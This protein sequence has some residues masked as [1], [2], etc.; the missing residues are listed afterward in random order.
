MHHNVSHARANITLCDKVNHIFLAKPLEECL[1]D[2]D[3]SLTGICKKWLWFLCI[4][5]SS[6]SFVDYLKRK[7]D[8]VDQRLFDLDYGSKH[9]DKDS[10][11]LKTTKNALDQHKVNLNV[12][13]F[14]FIRIYIFTF[15]IPFSL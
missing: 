1:D 14:H 6:T 7:L 3:Q 9:S 11:D 5:S 4:F 10:M 13:F 15:Y 2:L 8:A 12:W